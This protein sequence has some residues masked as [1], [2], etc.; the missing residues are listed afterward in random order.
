MK[1]W[2]RYMIVTVSGISY[3]TIFELRIHVKASF[4]IYVTMARSKWVSTSE[5]SRE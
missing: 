5:L 3:L 4:Q 1:M 2:L